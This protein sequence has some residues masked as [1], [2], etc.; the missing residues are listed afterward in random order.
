MTYSK[1]V[2]VMRSFLQGQGDA[3][4][5]PERL[6]RWSA[7]RRVADEDIIVAADGLF[8]QGLMVE[9]LDPHDKKIIDANAPGVRPKSL[10]RIPGMLCPGPIVCKEASI[11]F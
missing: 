3:V 10:Y 4:W 5:K 6:L 8:R 9:R 1:L 11:P 2:G 7:M